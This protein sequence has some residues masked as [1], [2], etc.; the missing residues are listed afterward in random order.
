M[1]HVKYVLK[2]SKKPPQKKPQPK[3]KH[4]KAFLFSRLQNV[5][6]ERSSMF[7]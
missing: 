6:T 5:Y 1:N 7:I 3:Q 4:S 2:Q